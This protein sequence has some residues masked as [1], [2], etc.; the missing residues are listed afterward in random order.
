MVGSGAALD[1]RLL[2]YGEVWSDVP[3]GS[4]FLI[5]LMEL[6]SVRVD[7]LENDSGGE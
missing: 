3:E 4:M 5:V 6:R 1:V 2:G 7:V